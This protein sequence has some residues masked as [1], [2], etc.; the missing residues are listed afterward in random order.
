MISKDDN[1]NNL[2]E[3]IYSY[4]PKND[5][6]TSKVYMDSIE[7]CNY[8]TVLQDDSRR[9]ELRDKCYSAICQVFMDNCMKQ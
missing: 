7:Y 6:F 2:F 4:Y 5:N 8:R 9:I 3:I 1:F